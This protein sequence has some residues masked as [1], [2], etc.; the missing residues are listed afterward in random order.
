MAEITIVPASIQLI[1]MTDAEYFS[2]KYKDYISNSRL[3]LINP[4][5]EGSPEKYD[6][7]FTSAFSESFELGSAIHAMI[8]QPDYYH[9]ANINKPTGKLGV[10]AEEVFKQRQLGY[11]IL[12][13]I[14]IASVNADYYASKF[15]NTRLKT[16]I[17]NSL[18]FYLQRIKFHGE[19]NKETIFLSAPMQQKFEQCM[20]GVAENPKMMNTLYPVGLL[21]SAEF[22]NEY[23]I[24]CEVDF[25]DEI[26]GEVT[27]L[28]LKAK[29]DN[30]TLDHETQTLTLNDL[31]STGKPVNYFMG[32]NVPI[33]QEDG[34]KTLQWYNGSFQRYH[35]YRQIGMY[36]WLLQAAVKEIYGLTYSLKANI[37][38]IETVPEFKSK[39]YPIAG[40]YIKTGLDEF[41]TL[42]TLVVRWKKRIK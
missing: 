29:L 3:G 4:E 42:L 9:I 18:S 14:T 12:N 17:K 30:F 26:T 40:K 39:V 5:E 33:T 10:F 1:K 15:S 36:L 11:N 38:A 35:Y 13:S 28:K 34:I 32:N 25:V 7:G 16:A 20:L 31:K 8:L 24:L 2:K 37:L 21:Q 27:R 19:L 6:T 22:F 23:A 41:K